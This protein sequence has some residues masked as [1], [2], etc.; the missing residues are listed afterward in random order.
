MIVQTYQ[1]KKCNVMNFFWGD[2]VAFSAT[3]NLFVLNKTCLN[4]FFIV[5]PP[6]VDVVGPSAPLKEGKYLNLLCDLH[7]K[8]AEGDIPKYVW[9]FQPKGSKVKIFIGDNRVYEKQRVT[10]IDTGKITIIFHHC[11]LLGYDFA[12]VGSFVCCRLQHIYVTQKVINGIVMKISRG[13]SNDTR[14]N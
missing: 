13:L 10:P 7:P 1:R 6:K 2:I 3:P 11:H 14:R 5:V 8:V 9:G 12:N 4:H